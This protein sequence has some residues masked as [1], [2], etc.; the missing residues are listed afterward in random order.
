MRNARTDMSSLM[1][2]V[3]AL[4]QAFAGVVAEVALFEFQS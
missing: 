1:I 4:F 3:R 2:V